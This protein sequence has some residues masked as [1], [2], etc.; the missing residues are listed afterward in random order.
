MRTV[1]ILVI[2]CAAAALSLGIAPGTAPNQAKS[3]AKSTA[4]TKTLGQ[5]EGIYRATGKPP[6]QQG[7]RRPWRRRRL[8]PSPRH[9]DLQPAPKPRPHPQLRVPRPLRSP[10]NRLP[11][12]RNCGS[13]LATAVFE[14]VSNGA[15]IPVESPAALIPFFEQLYRLQAGKASNPVRILHYGDSHTAADEWT[16]RDARSASRKDSEMEA[17]DILS[18]A[19]RGTATG[20]KMYVQRIDQWLAHRWF[21][22]ARRRRRLR[23]GW[24]QHVRACAP[25][26]PLRRGGRE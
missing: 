16:R 21:G 23:I 11:Y 2:A 13:R 22:R 14:Y 10:R 24:N 7:S 6:R 15:D 4:K 19:G 8:L 26:R 18:Q 5:E 25:G 20:V 12:R 9:R 1:Q 3:K 17:L